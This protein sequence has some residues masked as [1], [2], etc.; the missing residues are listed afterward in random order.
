MRRKAREKSKNERSKRE[1][2]RLAPRQNRVFLLL[3]PSFFL[4][5]WNRT[6]RSEFQ[7]GDSMKPTAVV[8]IASLLF[9]ILMPGLSIVARELRGEE[10]DRVDWPKAAGSIQSRQRSEE[11]R[12]AQNAARIIRSLYEMDVWVMSRRQ[13][14]LSKSKEGPL[15]ARDPQERKAPPTRQPASS[16]QQLTPMLSRSYPRR[17]SR[18]R[19]A[20]TTMP[21]LTQSSS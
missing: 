18:E 17:Q 1:L 4:P 12:A 2:T 14:D 16:S 11:D 20:Y 19:N 8:L 7:R 13:L 15:R 9:Q 5:S 10:T 3:L 6:V 21:T